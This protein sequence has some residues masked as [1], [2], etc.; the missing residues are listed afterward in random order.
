MK[1][2]GILGFGIVGKSVLR[3][4]KAYEHELSNRLFGASVALA[5][6]V[7]DKKNLTEQ[8]YALLS[9]YHAQ[10]MPR[11]DIQLFIDMHDFVVA[12]PGFDL[13][14]YND[15]SNKLLN[16]LDLFVPFFSKP[17]IGITGTLGKTSTTKLLTNMLNH[18]AINDYALHF[19]EGGNVGTAMLDLVAQQQEVD[20]AVLELSSWQLE[21][22]QS[23]A[24]D[25]AIWTNFFPNHLDRHGTMSAYAQAKY[26]LMRFQSAAQHAIIADQVLCDYD[27]RALLVDL[28]SRACVVTVQAREVIMPTLLWQS[29]DVVDVC[30]GW[31]RFSRIQNQQ[32]VEETLLVELATLPQST[33]VQNWLFV[34]A[35]LKIFGVDWFVVKKELSAGQVKGVEHRLEWCAAVSGVDFYN[36]SK[37]TVI[38][39]TQAA[40]EKLAGSGRPLLVIVG[41]LGKGADRSPLEKM[42]QEMPNV[43][44]RYCF[45]P[46]CAEFASCQRFGTLEQV[47]DQV[48]VDMAPGDVVLFSPSGSSYDLFENY[49]HR[50]RVFKDLVQRKANAVQSSQ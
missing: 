33:F 43:K 41:G 42:L 15:Q 28:Q 13:S 47:L 32:V 45:G 40:V 10:H 11:V 19:L 29:C 1:R 48:F 34:L 14:L 39:S 49:E 44:K 50:G 27:A 8:E 2:I 16:E 20:G 36:D 7:W 25:I 31:V 21:Y 38:Q 5:V 24:P 22:N 17:T 35:A 9:E 23:F 6:N 18:V 4:I 30:G 12:S 3:F 26:N 37:S 46:A